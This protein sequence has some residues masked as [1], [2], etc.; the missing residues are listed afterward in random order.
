MGVDVRREPPGEAGGHQSPDEPDQA[1]RGRRRITIA[2]GALLALAVIVVGYATLGPPLIPAGGGAGSHTTATATATLGPPRVLYQAD[3][4]HSAG[5]WSLTDHWQVRDGALVNDGQGTAALPVP[6][7]ITVPNYTITWKV[8]VVEVMPAVGGSKFGMV[9]LSQA[10]DDRPLFKAELT[11][12]RP[13]ASCIGFS[14]LGTQGADPNNTFNNSGAERN[15]SFTSYDFVSGSSLRTYRI[16]VQG[17]GM[18]LCIETTC[19]DSVTSVK[20]LAP[21]QL[22]LTNLYVQVAITSLVITTP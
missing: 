6:F 22:A 10:G 9:G 1:P 7:T 8:R 15:T 11:C 4:S 13:G 5:D 16:V 17:K 19:L 20:P 18:D 14:A 21:M 3:W 2:L 12:T